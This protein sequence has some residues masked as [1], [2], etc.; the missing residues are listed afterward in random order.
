MI[1]SGAWVL[2]GLVAVAGTGWPGAVFSALVMA[3]LWWPRRPPK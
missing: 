1:G 2:V 3:L